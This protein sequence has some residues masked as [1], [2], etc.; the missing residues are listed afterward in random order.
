MQWARK[1]QIEMNIEVSEKD[2]QEYADKRMKERIN[3][4]VEARL[5]EIDWYKRVDQTVFS[6][7]EKHV[8]LDRCNVIL[9]E[10]DRGKL[11]ESICKYMAEQIVQKL[12][13][14]Y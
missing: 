13:E 11:V 6:V 14:N 12:F 9:S 1:G 2:M 4:I 7:V 10:L 5:K 8:T 3:A